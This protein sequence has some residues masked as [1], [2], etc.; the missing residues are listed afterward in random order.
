MKRRFDDDPPRVR[1]ALKVIPEDFVVEEIPDSPPDGQGPHMLLWVEKRALETRDVVEALG[2]LLGIPRAE[3]GVAGQKDRQAVTRQ[4]ISVPAHALYRKVDQVGTNHSDGQCASTAEVTRP[5]RTRDATLPAPF[6]SLALPSGKG[7]RVLS[8]HPHSSKLRTGHLLGNSFC[9]RVRGGAEDAAVA[10]EHLD[11]LSNNGIPN[12]FG[13]QRFGRR[14][15]NAALGL[16]LLFGQRLEKNRFK[17]RMYI[18][19]LQ[20]RLFN[21]W[22]DRRIEDGLLDKAIPGDVLRDRASGWQG[23]GSFGVL[24]HCENQEADSLAVMGGKTDPTGP[25]FGPHMKTALEDAASREAAVLDASGLTLDHFN[26]VERD[27]PG[28]RRPARTWMDETRLEVEGDDILIS[29]SLERG[30]YATVALAQLGLTV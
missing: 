27:A 9:I 2:R 7:W 30:A 13:P 23:E 14:A 25:I 5:I 16:E 18:S 1:G 22:L 15:D 17:R 19:A 20:S 3:I 29:F 8:A 26:A 28:S 10:N 21:E 11:R 6:S 24:R 4:W 12:Y